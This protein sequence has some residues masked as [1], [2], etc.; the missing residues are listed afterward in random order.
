MLPVSAKGYMAF[1][2]IGQLGY[3]KYWR[4][5]KKGG[6]NPNSTNFKRNFL[7]KAEAHPTEVLQLLL[8]AAIHSSEKQS[9]HNP[10]LKVLLFNQRSCA[11]PGLTH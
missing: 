6:K 11:V 2:E 9:R 1:T 10:G 5:E 8:Y 4:V 7:S 3:I